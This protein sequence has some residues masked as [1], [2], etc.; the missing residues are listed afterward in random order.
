M[1]YSYFELCIAILKLY[2]P[3]D[4]LDPLLPYQTFQAYYQ[5]VPFNEPTLVTS[6]N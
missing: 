1:L 4:Q 6:S 5:E 3:F 2:L